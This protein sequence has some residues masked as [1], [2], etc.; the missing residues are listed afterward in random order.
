MD[1]N[2]AKKIEDFFSVYPLFKYERG[3]IL[4]HAG[5]QPPGI[6]HL[7]S[8]KVK[9][10]GLASKGSELVLNVFKP[11]AFFPMAHALNRTPNNYYYEAEETVQL[12]LA[13]IDEVV[14]FLKKN[15]DVLYDLLSRVY[16]GAEG[17]LNR[18]AYLMSG[19]ARS[20]LINELI[21][22][23]RRFGKQESQAVIITLSEGDLGAR[24]GLSRET[25]NREIHKLKSEG[26]LDIRQRQIVVNSLPKLQ[27]SLTK[28]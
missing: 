13:P 8:G 11:P 26:L 27:E 28:E 23:C 19:T 4:L 25:V 18:M 3:Q 2:I 17:I 12:H 14:E 20:R 7:V 10:C 1:E 22:E 6:Y 24:A 5:E 16:R 15:P 21:I 9:Q